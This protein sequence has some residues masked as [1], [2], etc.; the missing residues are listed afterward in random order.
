MISPGGIPLYTGDFGE[1]AKAVESL[2]SDA[3]GIRSGGRDAH[4][5]FQA[6]A[7]Y[8]VAPE[9]DQLLASTQPVMDKADEFAGAIESLADALETFA[10]EAKPHADRLKELKQQA[11]AFVR[12]VD[13]DDDWTEDKEKVD[14][15]EALL[16][17]VAVARAG[18]KEAERDAANAINALSTVICRPAWVPDDGTHKPG[19]Y[20]ES[21]E[22]LKGAKDLPWGSPE[23]QTYER[24][25][26]DWWGHGAKSWVW[27][28][29][30]VDSVVG[31]LD[32]LGT[33]VGFHGTDARDEAWDGLGRTFVGGYAYGMDLIGQGDA[34]SDWQRESKAY[35]K[36]FGKQF[37]AYDMWEEDPARAH[38]VVSFNLLTLGSGPLAA[39]AK[40]G[41]GGSLARAAGTV[42]KVGDLVDPLSGALKATKALADLPKVSAVVANISESLKL[43][44][45][46]FP[47]GVLDLD[48]R[49]RIDADGNLVPIN[50][51]GTPH[52]APPRQEPSA[53][54]RATGSPDRDRELVGAGARRPENSVG[55]GDHT[56]LGDDVPGDRPGGAG[57]AGAPAGPNGAST[58]GGS[59]SGHFPAGGEPGGAGHGAGDGHGAGV[60]DGPGGGAAD[61]PDAQT[62]NDQSSDGSRP[63]ANGQPDSFPPPQE[64][65]PFVRGGETEQQIREVLSRGKPKPGDLEKA[66]ANLAEH[67]AGQEIADLIAS[68]RFKGLTNFEDVVS[69]FSHQNMMPGGFEQLRLAARL[70]ENGISDISFDIKENVELR[71]GVS[72]G[73]D[74][75]MDVMARTSD[76][77]IYGYQFKGVSNPKKSIQKIWDNID[78]LESCKADVKVFVLDT[79]GTMASLLASK[80]EGRLARIYAETGVSVVLRV[81]DGTL[82]YPPGATFIP[83]VRS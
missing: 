47:D 66:L 67:P 57:H 71:P 17:D 70:Q 62:G 23:G 14:K 73:P 35:A 53:A 69:A 58:S 21:A 49:Y 43:P 19:M 50:P 81:E 13:G 74:T 22:L 26:L 30:V 59:H 7:A 65:R 28:G 18:F 44:P 9:S 32:G 10:A 12:S 55:S 46:K 41:K 72:T 77:K 82:M 42:A 15:H 20:G 3:I 51:D 38:A 40:L 27:D 4:S 11:F 37:V 36:E 78:Q 75:D 25:S 39:A 64:S 31:G 34:L 8:Y 52:T 45:S 5:R 83:G 63:P 48:D 76:G 2:R 56:R 24:W 33:L 1:L 61:G 80:I 16:D 54:D 6:V 29:L 68:G 60:P 79:K